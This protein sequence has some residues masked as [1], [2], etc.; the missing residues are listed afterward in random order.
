MVILITGGTGLIGTLLSKKLLAKGHTVRV[1]SRSKRKIPGIEVFTWDYTKNHLEAGAM[2]G[3]EVLVHLAGE[4]IAESSWTENRKKQLISS[5][6]DSLN[7]LNNYV[8]KTLHTLIGG[9]ATGFYGGNTGENLSTIESPAGNDFLAKCTKIWEKTEEEFA[10][11]HNLELSIIRTGVVLSSNGG[12][13][14]KL[15]GPVKAYIGSPLGTGSQWVSW[16]HEQDLVDVFV[17]AI[18][19]PNQAIVN[20]VAPNPATNTQMLKAIAKTLNKP[21]FMPNVPGFV[22]KIILGE[23]ATVV[24]GSAKVESNVPKENFKFPNIDSAIEDLLKP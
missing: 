10:K 20:A 11:K 3:V 22:L 14:P 9:S 18:E 12:A 17:D 6:V 15:A 2:Y 23:M 19:N 16:I 4:G 5:R 13:L 1:L 24:L 21:T 8:P 7:F